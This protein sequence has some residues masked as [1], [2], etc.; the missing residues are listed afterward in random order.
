MVRRPLF[1]EPIE[2][3]AKVCRAR[4]GDLNSVLVEANFEDLV[5]DI[6]LNFPAHVHYIQTEDCG[7]S[8]N[9]AGA[10]GLE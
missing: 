2:V 4:A 8:V 9:L 7:G 5:G 1:V 3:I 6:A 10:W